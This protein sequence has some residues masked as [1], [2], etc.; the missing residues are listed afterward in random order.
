[1]AGDIKVPFG[2]DVPRLMDDTLAKNKP[3]EHM[4]SGEISNG[5][6][7]VKIRIFRKKLHIIS[8]FQYDIALMHFSL[9][10]CT[11]NLYFFTYSIVHV[12][13]LK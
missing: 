6:N 4:G 8:N 12:E 11:P 5:A 9:C 3:S 10:K 13:A 7:C 2:H 1:M